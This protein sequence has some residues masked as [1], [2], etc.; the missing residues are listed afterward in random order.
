[1]NII[2]SS[3]IVQPQ[4][5]QNHCRKQRVFP[6]KNKETYKQQQKKGFTSHVC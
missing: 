1:M 6:N 2:I 4:C 5:K 3:R